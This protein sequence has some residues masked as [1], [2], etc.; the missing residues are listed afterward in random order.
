MLSKQSN[1]LA[2][3]EQVGP[4]RPPS[5]ALDHSDPDGFLW[6]ES[7]QFLPHDV[8]VCPLLLSLGT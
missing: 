5:V 4:Q 2:V 6:L 7:P 1:L 8:L 3:E